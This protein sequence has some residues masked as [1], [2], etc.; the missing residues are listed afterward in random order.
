MEYRFFGDKRMVTWV[1]MQIEK[2]ENNVKDKV[3][4]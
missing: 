4:R 2:I 3:N 1:K